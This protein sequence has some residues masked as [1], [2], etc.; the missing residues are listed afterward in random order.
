[1]AYGA[2][3]VLAFGLP[4]VGLLPDIG[5]A[6]MAASAALLVFGRHDL[7]TTAPELVAGLT[8]IEIPAIV[9]ERHA[10]N[11]R[12]DR[13]DAVTDDGRSLTIEVFGR[14][15]RSS[16]LLPRAWRLVR[17]RRSGDRRPFA[18]LRRSV[19][20]EA[21]VSLHVAGLGIRTPGLLGVAEAGR[22]GLALVY[23]AVPGAEGAENVDDTA[24]RELWA[25]VRTMHDRRIAHRDLRMDN[26]IVDDGGRTWL[27]GFG[28]SE[29]TASDELLALDRAELLAA[30]SVEVGVDPAID[31]ALASFEPGELADALPWLQPLA[32]SRSTRAAIGDDANVAHLRDRL[33]ERCG[34]DDVQPVRSQRITGANLFLLAT[35]GIGAWV[36]LP[37][38]ADV[39]EIWTQIRSAS[40][41]WAAVAVVCSGVSYPAA[42]TSLLGA[43]PT[44]VSS[45]RRSSL[46]SH[47]RSRI[48]RPPPRSAG[49]RRTCATSSSRVSRRRSASARSG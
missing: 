32:L 25:A 5:A 33:A 40:V 20:H 29:L 47:R 10:G 13:W 49:S 7:A 45:V 22:D 17:Y 36:L 23:L 38:F 11:G 15:E 16:D 42:T 21:L 41:G 34:V 24:G 28:R 39:D 6:M 12:A 19:E 3:R 18:S 14:D 46:S 44:R 35:T 48:D 1:M 30:T 43:I 37:Q 9:G 27:S 4:A 26:V 2:V 31:A 8:A